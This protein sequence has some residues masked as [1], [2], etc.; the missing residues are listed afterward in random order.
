MGDTSIETI[1]IVLDKKLLLATDGAAPGAKRID[2]PWFAMLCESTYADC[3]SGEK[4]RNR[5]LV[6][7][8]CTT[9]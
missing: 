4:L 3:R 9:R 5:L 6:R 7:L 1:Q 8:I 2:R